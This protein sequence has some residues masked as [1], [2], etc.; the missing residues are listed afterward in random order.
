MDDAVHDRLTWLNDIMVE[1]MTYIVWMDDYHV[2]I[3]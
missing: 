3:T 2:I 1:K